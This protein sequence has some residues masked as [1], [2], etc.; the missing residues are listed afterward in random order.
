MTRARHPRGRVIGLAAVTALLV[1]AVLLFLTRPSADDAG[2]VDAAL[3][4]PSATGGSSSSSSTA[5]SPTSSQTSP[6]PGSTK[7]AKAPRTAVATAPATPSAAPPAPTSVSV[8]ELDATLPVRPVGVDTT[9]AMSIPEDP[10]QA[11]WYKFGSAPGQDG[12]TV[13]TAHVDTKELG[14]GPLARLDTLSKGDA[15]TVRTSAGTTTYRVREVVLARK[16]ELDLDALFRRSGR[17]ALHLV[18]CGGAFDPKTG[19]YEDNVVAI[20]DPA[21]G[22]E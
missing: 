22:R 10:R 5:P 20:A 11:G 4:G 2:T 16:T 6:S 3:S 9:G 13:I 7:A 15:V 18:T 21:T 14:P 19:H 8:P 12:A 17:P 1:G